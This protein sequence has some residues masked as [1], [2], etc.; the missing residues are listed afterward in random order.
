MRPDRALL[1]SAAMGEGHDAAGRAVAAAVARLW[2]ETTVDWVDVLAT[3]GHGTESLFDRIYA[4]S[5]ERWPWVYEYYYGSL[6][7]RRW[8]AAA[9]K[10][11][12]GR[13]T[14]RRLVCSRPGE[15]AGLAGE[16]AH[17]RRAVL[18]LEVGARRYANAHDVGDGLLALA[19]TRPAGGATAAG[20]QGSRT[21]LASMNAR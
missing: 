8:F 15:L 11:F 3:L 21:G 16:L 7:R 20:D 9:A 18:E 10:R 6:W 17:D 1:V 5:V 14:G 13:W 4:S 12:I 19:G 2:P